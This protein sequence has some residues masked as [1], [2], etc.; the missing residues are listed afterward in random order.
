MKNNEEDEFVW[1]I[2]GCCV[3]LTT[4]DFFF[5]LFAHQMDK[6]GKYDLGL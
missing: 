4:F 3:A 5:V 1:L 2:Y 6:N